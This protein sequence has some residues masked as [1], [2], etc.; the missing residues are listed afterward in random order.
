[1]PPEQRRKV[2][3]FYTPAKKSRFAIET[4]RGSWAN[5]YERSVI[6]TRKEERYLLRN[7]W[8]VEQT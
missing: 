4:Q 8:P 7:T 5:C 6:L 3:E 2:I 1:M